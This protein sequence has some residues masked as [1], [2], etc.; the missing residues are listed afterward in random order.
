MTG[1]YEATCIR[2]YIYSDE[3][4]ILNTGHRNTRDPPPGHSKLPHRH[5]R[6]KFLG[7]AKIQ[8][9]L[10]RNFG[11]SLR[12]V[13]KNL[14]QEGCRTRTGLDS[15]SKVEIG[16]GRV[17]RQR[18][19][20]STMRHRAERLASQEDQPQHGP[21][22]HFEDTTEVEDVAADSNVDAKVEDVA[23]THDSN[24]EVDAES[25]EPSRIRLLYLPSL[26]G[27]ILKRTQFTCL[28]VR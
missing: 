6:W 8:G 23:S 25:T 21:P 17:N 2:L 15:N 3:Y 18:P 24:L 20:V 11:R 27:G 14:R 22:D 12:E 13:K 4:L 10:C 26:R 16:S 28:L 9:R 1:F 19:T 5:V 7:L